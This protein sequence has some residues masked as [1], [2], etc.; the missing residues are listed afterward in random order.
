MKN[1]IMFLFAVI[2]STS[3]L[4]SCGTTEDR[5]F[6][7]M[8]TEAT[9][10]PFQFRDTNGDVVGFDIE[11]SQKIAEKLE[12]ELMIEDVD[13]A[14][15]IPMLETGRIDF[16]AAGLTVTE[17]RKQNVDFSIPYFEATQ[18]VLVNDDNLEINTL[19]DLNGLR[20][21]TQF[22]TAGERIA[23]YEVDNATVISFNSIFHAVSDL[24]IGR[25]DAIIIDDQPS[26]RIIDINSNIRLIDINLP[27]EEY[28]IAVAKG[29]EEL[30]NVIN[31]VIEEL[32]ESGEYDI[33]LDKYF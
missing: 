26:K 3:L 18:V 25:I 9:F 29:N 28:A 12:K 24:N 21:G 8:G 10:E 16:I 17:E 13:F 20:I 2:F 15:L 22:G 32:M 14:G 5:N 31:L 4:T 27:K 19:Q 23:T 6:V 7:I 11:I 30:L 33:L 1:I